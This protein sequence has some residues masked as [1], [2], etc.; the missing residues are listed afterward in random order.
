MPNLRR[1]PL[2]IRPAP[3]LQDAALI[4][5]HDLEGA[6]IRDIIELAGHQAITDLRVLEGETAAEP[7]TQA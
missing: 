4:V 5:G 6:G 7:T 1:A 2:R 3:Q